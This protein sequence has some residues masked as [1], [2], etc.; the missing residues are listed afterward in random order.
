MSYHYLY[1]EVGGC[2]MK[3]VGSAPASTAFQTSYWPPA[4]SAW[5]NEEHLRTASCVCASYRRS[6]QTHCGSFLA[7]NAPTRNRLHW[8]HYQWNPNLQGN[9]ES[10]WISLASLLA[11]TLRKQLDNWV[12]GLWRKIS[13]LEQ[14]YGRCAYLISHKELQI[15]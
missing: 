13:V 7:R 8:E 6:P 3:G 5:R 9:N 12:V 2:W 15:L 1:Y 4:V 14:I 11:H 10:I